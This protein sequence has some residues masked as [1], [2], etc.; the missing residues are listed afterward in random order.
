MKPWGIV[1]PAASPRD[2]VVRL[3]AAT[4]KLLTEPDVKARLAREGAEIISGSPDEFATLIARNL[5]AWK[6]LIA[7]AHL[8]L[9]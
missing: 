1:A 2:I 9:E 6:K 5:A 3:N 4:R 8:E 7:D